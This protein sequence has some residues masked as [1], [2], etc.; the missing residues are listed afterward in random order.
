VERKRRS[1]RVEGS[2]RPRD[3]GGRG[4][5]VRE[6]DVLPAAVARALGTSRRAGEQALRGPLNLARRCARVINVL[7]AAGADEALVWFLQPIDLA[8]HAAQPDA[9]TTAAAISA[10]T[11]AHDVEPPAAV[12]PRDSAQAYLNRLYEEIGARTDPHRSA[13]SEVW[14]GSTF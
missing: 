5:A 8:V 6:A 13:G 10:H 7:K 1:I 2:R 11:V 4:A 12:P 3:A 14:D 9:V